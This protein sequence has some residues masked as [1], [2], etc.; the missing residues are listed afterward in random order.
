M[1]L[2]TI[3]S[4][5]IGILGLLAT[6][7]GLAAAVRSNRLLTKGMKIGALRQI[8]TAINRLEA[9]KKKHPSSSPQYSVMNHTQEDLE[10][11]FKN[12]QTT[13]RVSERDAPR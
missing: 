10:D 13:F 12:I 4:L 11:V 3:L 1:E 2:V 9:E 8:R 6:I 5:V 7:W